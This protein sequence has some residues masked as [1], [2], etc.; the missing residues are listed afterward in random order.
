MRVLLRLV[1][2][3]LVIATASSPRALADPAAP[4]RDP[5]AV[6]LA[7]QYVDAGLAAQ[8]AHDYDTAIALYSRAY[9]LVPHP[10]LIFNLAQAH[11]LAGHPDEALVLYQQYL[12]KGPSGAQATIARGL[13]AALLE[14]QAKKQRAVAAAER[15]AEAAER[16]PAAVESPRKDADKVDPPG[17]PAAGRPADAVE[18]QPEPPAADRAASTGAIV[19]VAR[20]QADDSIPRGA[21][22]VDDERRGELVHGKLV[23][24]QLA[25]G[26]HTVAIEA[27]GYQRFEHTATVRGGEKTR[28][29][30][31]LV[32]A[33][34]V[35]S[36]WKWVLGT[37]LGVT[38]SS[39]GFTTYAWSRT[40]DL[41]HGISAE[42]PV[43][44][45]NCGQSPAALGLSSGDAERFE[46]ACAWTSR[47]KVGVLVTS[48]ALAVSAVSLVMVL[49]DTGTPEPGAMA[50]RGTRHEV[51][52]APIVAPG[53]GGASLSVTW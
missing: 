46:Q 51:A 31:E 26:R 52:I 16:S 34:P 19:I 53:A 23:V 29:D 33:P 9:Q 3:G 12:A 32:D 48:V 35:R 14:R 50:T 38:L 40:R 24:S 43:S 15:A 4:A 5:A 2:L 22:L 45:S 41:A 8:E 42:H 11:R 1:L 37:S 28:L 6:K 39:A 30:A 18:Q 25:D 49:R 10:L 44:S 36:A 17:E 27:R 7:K 21:V 13:V 47:Q 20:N